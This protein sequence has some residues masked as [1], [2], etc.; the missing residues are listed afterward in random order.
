MRLGWSE[1]TS[2]N[3]AKGQV[4]R[5]SK[6]E[7]PTRTAWESS[8]VSNSS[9][10]GLQGWQVGSENDPDHYPSDKNMSTPKG[11]GTLPPPSIHYFPCN[12][13]REYMGEG[14]L[15]W[16]YPSLLY[17]GGGNAQI[18]RPSQDHDSLVIFWGRTPSSRNDQRIH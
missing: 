1:A 7:R 4:E 8:M 14:S 15:C 5:L 2:Y 3:Q 9:S 16:E 18:H 10:K 13:Q 6:F 17:S 12:P 11:E